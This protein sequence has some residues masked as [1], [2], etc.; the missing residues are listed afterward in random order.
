VANPETAQPK[1]ESYFD[2]SK[3]SVREHSDTPTTA[4][5]HHQHAK[6]PAHPS[7]RVV[8]QLNASWRVVDDPLQ[9][10]LQRRKGSARSKNSGWQGR[11]FCRTREAL[12]RCIREYCAEID[13]GALA[14][15]EAVP[16][17]HPDWDCRD[18]RTNLDVLGTDRYQADSRQELNA[19]QAL[20]PC[21]AGEQTLAT[22][23]SALL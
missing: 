15:L 4:P 2:T 18:E 13:D 23:Q 10:I 19:P 12:L 9:W 8:T 1:N 17:W 7:N 3:S 11:S 6:R 14:K 16:V 21:G 22:A 5:G 20:E